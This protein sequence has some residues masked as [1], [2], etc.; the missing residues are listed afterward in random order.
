MV[1]LKKGPPSKL[2]FV[3]DRQKKD[4]LALLRTDT[5]LAET[6]VVWVYGKRWDIEVFFKM[7]KQHLKLAKEIQ[8]RDFD[9]LIAHTSIMSLSFECRLAADQRTFGDLLYACCEGMRDLTF[10]ESLMRIIFLAVDR[11]RKLGT[12]CQHT[13]QV[14]FHKVFKGAME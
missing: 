11:M 13:C 1:T 12:F 6:D 4:W 5:E 9:A 10:M 3:S 8:C 2:V 14:I 7:A